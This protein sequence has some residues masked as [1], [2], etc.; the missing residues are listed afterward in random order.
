MVVKVLDK[1]TGELVR[2]IPADTAG[3]VLLALPVG[4]ILTAPVAGSSRM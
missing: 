1:E 3:T 2:Q 4:M